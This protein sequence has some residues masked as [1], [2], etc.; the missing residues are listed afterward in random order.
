M[1]ICHLSNFDARPASFQIENGGY[2][3]RV[4]YGLSSRFSQSYNTIGL[5]LLDVKVALNPLYV[6]VGL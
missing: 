1:I 3:I 6:V 5:Y 4:F 2:V